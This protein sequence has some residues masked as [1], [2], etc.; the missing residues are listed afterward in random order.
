MKP[1]TNQLL[2]ASCP[3]G[4]NFYNPELHNEVLSPENVDRVN[5]MFKNA[6]RIKCGRIIP[7]QDYV[8]LHTQMTDTL[9]DVM[10]NDKRMHNGIAPQM[11]KRALMGK[12]LMIRYSDEEH[13]PIT[14]RTRTSLI[15]EV[16]SRT[17]RRLTKFAIKKIRLEQRY[18][19]ELE[20]DFSERHRLATTR[21]EV[22]FYRNRVNKIGVTP[23]QGIN[24]PWH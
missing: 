6:I 21:P 1:I 17:V 2:L 22:V 18:R 9:Y 10:Y 5:A 19:D 20:R 16:N 14:N 3:D 15:N 24:Y 23:T 12:R 11:L 8:M 13:G 7:D 4:P